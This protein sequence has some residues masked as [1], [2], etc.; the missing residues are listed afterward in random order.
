M[1]KQ[2]MITSVFVC[3]LFTSCSESG[4]FYELPN[5]VNYKI[6]D[7]AGELHQ[8]GTGEKVDITDFKSG[9]YFI[10]YDGIKEKIEVD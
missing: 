1:I 7:I 4:K 10:S 6:Y 5:S 9:I 3:L 2:L 8:E